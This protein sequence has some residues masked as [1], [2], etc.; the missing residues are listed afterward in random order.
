MTLYP[1]VSVIMP[2]YNRAQIIGDTI[3][4]LFRQTYQNLE[5]I[6]VDD[7]STDETQAKLDSYGNRIRWVAQKNAGPAAARNRGIAMAEGEIIAFQDSDDVWHPAK[8]E[9]QVSLLQR[10]GESVVC[11]VCNCIVQ[12]PHR[13]VQ[14]FECAPV[15]F[16][17]EEGVW[18]NVPEVLAT[19]F[20]LFNQAVAVRREVLARVGGFDESFRLMEDLQLALR[21]SLEGPWA[22]IRE[23]LATRR[24]RGERTLGDEATPK[25]VCEN[26]VRI[27]EG[28]LRVVERNDQLA[29]LK[30]LMERE[31]RRARRGLRVVELQCT[32]TFAESTLGW[33]LE[34]V[35]RCRMAAGRRAPWLPQMKVYAV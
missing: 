2:T 29:P 17:I 11:C 14:S 13:V 34:R 15:S 24:E 30:P 25:V 35:E 19:R 18:L 3:E 33:I 6:V 27:R 22:F 23:P 1:L 32:K 20:F 16:P 4:D 7:G 8:I 12:L 21:L 31:L 28:L 26:N 5:I 10:A 9:R